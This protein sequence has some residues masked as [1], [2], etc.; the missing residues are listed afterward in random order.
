MK[1]KGVHFLDKQ[2]AKLLVANVA[3]LSIKLFLLH[4]LLVLSSMLQML[5]LIITYGILIFQLHL[6]K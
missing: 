1:E 2:F 5:S 6:G 4:Q 3:K